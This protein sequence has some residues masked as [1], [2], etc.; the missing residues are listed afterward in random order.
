MNR[1]GTDLTSFAEKT[2]WV[3][4]VCVCV[5]VCVRVCAHVHV[6]AEIQL[7]W[8]S[9]IPLHLTVSRQG[10]SLNLGLTGSQLSWRKPACP[11]N[12]PTST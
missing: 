5:H 9:S 3:L 8:V 2:V 6:E 4:Y 7:P 12:P 11:S 10:L 1:N